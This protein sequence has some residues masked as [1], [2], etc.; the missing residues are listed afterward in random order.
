[1]IQCF[2]T[3]SRKYQYKGVNKTFCTNETMFYLY[4]TNPEAD[5]SDE[6]QDRSGKDAGCKWLRSG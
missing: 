6:K 5:S 1:M 3:G 4:Y 2:I